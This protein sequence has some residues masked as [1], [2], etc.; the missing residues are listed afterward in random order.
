[1]LTVGGCMSVKLLQ[2]TEFV[3]NIYHLFSVA[4]VVTAGED[5]FN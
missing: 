1:M 3:E 2:E 4:A 5:I